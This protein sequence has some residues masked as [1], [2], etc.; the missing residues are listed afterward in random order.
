MKMI[1]SGLPAPVDKVEKIGFEEKEYLPLTQF[2]HYIKDC[3]AIGFGK[4]LDAAGLREPRTKSPTTLAIEGGFTTPKFFVNGGDSGYYY[5]WHFQKTKDYLI[6][7]GVPMLSENEVI[8]SRIIDTVVW[9]IIKNSEN[10]ERQSLEFHQIPDINDRTKALRELEEMI[11]NAIKFTYEKWI[12]FKEFDI[13][14]LNVIIE[15]IKSFERKNKKTLIGMQC[16]MDFEQIR[17]LKVL[18]MIE[19]LEM[20]K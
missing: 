20:N 14:A 17:A 8:R 11:R 3:D 9:S 12:I 10:Y 13:G 2:A 4:L 19:N 6:S 15:N 5:Q 7:L 1:V 16:F 18:E